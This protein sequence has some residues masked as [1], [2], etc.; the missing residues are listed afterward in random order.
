MILSNQKLNTWVE[1]SK[2]ISIKYEL[3]KP[4]KE[5]A[6]IKRPPKKEAFYR[7]QKNAAPK[8]P[9]IELRFF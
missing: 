8:S 3:K 4:F 2:D 9:V 7:L 6:K 5:L 1:N